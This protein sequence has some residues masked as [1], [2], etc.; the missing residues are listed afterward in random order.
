VIRD[1]QG[2][3][4]LTGWKFISSASSADRWR[5]WHAGKDWLLLR[6]GLRSG[7]FSKS[8]CVAVIKSLKYPQHQR[9]P[10]TFIIQEALEEACKLPSILFLQIGREQNCGA[11]ELAQ[12]AKRIRHS[13]VWRERVPVCVEQFVAHDVNIPVN[14]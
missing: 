13:T 12:M 3:V 5:R 6:N 10:S 7:S 14:P 2:Q 1:H 8:D 4:V 9:S 11:H